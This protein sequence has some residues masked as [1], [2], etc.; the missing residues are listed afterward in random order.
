[1]LSTSLL[2]IMPASVPTIGASAAIFGLM[3]TAMLVKPFE[4]V[5]YPYLIP[6]PLIIVALLYTLYNIG[7][8]VAVLF[9]GEASE[10]AYAAHIGGLFTGALFG[11]REEGAK[12]GILVL[13][14]IILLLVLIPVLWGALQYLEIFNYISAFTG[15]FK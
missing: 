10:I 6:V 2:G 1:M 14:M 15:I 5:F 3:G 11:F 8:F 9:L 13:V 7:A 12:R 4:F